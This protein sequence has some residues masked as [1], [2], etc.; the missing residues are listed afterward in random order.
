MGLAAVAA[1]WHVAVF[2]RRVPARSVVT[3]PATLL[4]WRVPA[5]APGASS[6][7]ANRAPSKPVGTYCAGQLALTFGMAVITLARWLQIMRI[8]G[9]R[10]L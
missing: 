8:N 10:G 5:E 2:A 7:A 6:R 9:A 1:A 4:I 3:G